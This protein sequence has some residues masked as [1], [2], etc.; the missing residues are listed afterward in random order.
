MEQILSEDYWEGYYAMRSGDLIKCTDSVAGSVDYCVYDLR[1]GT[2][3]DEGRFAYTEGTLFSDFAREAAG[4][5]RSEIFLRISDQAENPDRHDQIDSILNGTPDAFSLLQIQ[6]LVRHIKNRGISVFGGPIGGQD[7]YEGD[8]EG[9][10]RMEDGSI[11]YCRNLQNWDDDDIDSIVDG[12]V[13]YL[14]LDPERFDIDSVSPKLFGYLDGEKFS[15][16]AEHL[17][18]SHGKITAC[19]GHRDD[20]MFGRLFKAMNGD[21]ESASIASHRLRIN[22]NIRHG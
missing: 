20:E 3:K 15:E 10:Y 18:P 11:L 8:F 16:L 17:S 14:I 7:L 22:L 6:N 12:V 4:T 19:L 21:P 5:T 9:F 1:K 13:S 2:R